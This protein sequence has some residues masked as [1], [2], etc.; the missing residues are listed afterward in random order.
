MMP[1]LCDS[2]G[3]Y[4]S[5]SHALDCCKGGLASQCHSEA[6]DTWGNLAVLAYR[7]IICES[8]V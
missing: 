4:F 1:S 8:I 7:V 6:R 3:S 5:L 2:Y